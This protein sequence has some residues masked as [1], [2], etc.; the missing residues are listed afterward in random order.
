LRILQSETTLSLHAGEDLLRA[1]QAAGHP[2]STSCGGRATCGLCR[3]VVRSGKE[4]LTPLNSQELIHLGN[5]ARVIG[6]R[7]ACQACVAHEGEIL[8]DVPAVDPIELRKLA[9]ASRIQRQRALE[10]QHRAG[11]LPFTDSPTP[12]P[13]TATEVL[14]GR[15]SPGGQV[16][17]RRREGAGDA[18]G[19]NRPSEVHGEVREGV[20]KNPEERVGGGRDEGRSGGNAGGRGE[21]KKGAKIEWRPRKLNEPVTPTKGRKER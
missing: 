10:A 15:E 14:R 8:V 20:S 16:L 5:V 19:A 2:I 7:L 12:P 6:A 21:D 9:K 17:L 13:T 11:G 18:A 4:H 1:L 3:L